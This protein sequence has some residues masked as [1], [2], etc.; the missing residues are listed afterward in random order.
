MAFDDDVPDPETRVTPLGDLDADV[1]QVVLPGV[2][3]ADLSWLSAGCLDVF[4][5]I[6]SN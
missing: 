2:L 4:A 5:I 6:S 3:N 1:L